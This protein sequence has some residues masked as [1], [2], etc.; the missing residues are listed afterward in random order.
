MSPSFI[1]IL[2][3]FFLRTGSAGSYNIYGLSICY[4]GLSLPP[5]RVPGP[6]LRQEYCCCSCRDSLISRMCY[7][8][9]G[10]SPTEQSR[11][12]RMLVARCPLCEAEPGSGAVAPSSMNSSSRIFPPTS[13]VYSVYPTIHSA[14]PQ[15]TRLVLSLHCCISLTAPQGCPIFSHCGRITGA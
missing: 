6:T 13:F 10:A 11:V 9:R 14:V 4:A 7:I 12:A 8:T 3:A 15:L 5:L 2:P 1:N